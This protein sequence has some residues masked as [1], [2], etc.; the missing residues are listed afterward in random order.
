LDSPVVAE[1]TPPGAN[2]P[3]LDTPVVPE[4]E[5]PKEQVQ[6]KPILSTPVVPEPEKPVVA[7]PQKPTKP[8]LSTPVV[9][10]PAA[11]IAKT[12]EGFAVP[13]GAQPPAPPSKEPFQAAVAPPAQAPA[14]PPAK[15]V[16]IPD[17]IDVGFG[18]GVPPPVTTAEQEAEK[19]APGSG[20]AAVQAGQEQAKEA[21]TLPAA[22]TSDDSTITHQD[23]VDA[24]RNKFTNSEDLLNRAK[25]FSPDEAAKLD[26]VFKDA[27]IQTEQSREKEFQEDPLKATVLG[28]GRGVVGTART[29]GG[30]AQ[31][32]NAVPG[33]VEGAVKFGINQGVAEH[34]LTMLATR[35]PISD[36]DEA[37]LRTLF[38]EIQGAG[39][40][41]QDTLGWTLT[42]L[43]SWYNAATNSRVLVPTPEQMVADPNNPLRS[44][45]LFGQIARMAPDERARYLDA[46]FAVA[47]QNQINDQL[48]ASGHLEPGYASAFW[49]LLQKTPQTVEALHQ[50]GDRRRSAGDPGRQFGL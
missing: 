14:P 10:E 2:K 25:Q 35:Q 33:L 42:R 13:S 27:I 29:I 48:R 18:P 38:A 15:P 40:N 5:K 21:A 34:A 23:K 46:E 41:A 11:P 12:A 6:A 44:N 3:L 32:I 39:H 7:E 26:P 36:S 20:Q 22:L 28:I 4:P 17:N 24:A 9:E 16:S 37:A 19:A 31:V 30:M 1:P 43:L 49:G 45:M 47:R 50:K 8:L